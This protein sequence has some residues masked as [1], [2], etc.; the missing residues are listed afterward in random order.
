[1]KKLAL[2]FIAMGL[3]GYVCAQEQENEEEGMMSKRGISI[4][5]ESG[6]IGLGI[7]GIPI[8]SYFGNIFNGTA[9]NTAAF[10]FV[11]GNNAIYGKYFLDE[12]TAVRAKVRINTG[13]VTD[14]E[15]V[16]K[17][18][19]PYYDENT[20]KD[21]QHISTT[22]V[23]LSTG[24]EMRRGKG[25]IQGFYGGEVIATYTNRITTYEY[26]NAFSADITNPNT[27][28]FGSNVTYTASGTGV[29]SRVL[30]QK[31]GRQL[32]FGLG[33]FI[34]VEYFFAPKIAVGGEF[35]WGF[36]FTNTADGELTNEVYDVNNMVIT[37]KTVET[38]GGNSW[39]VDTDN[40]FGAIYLMFHF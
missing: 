31:N 17:D 21:Y 8:I 30:E 3:I 13:T 29:E 23:Y 25:R 18:T 34:G 1:M 2:I 40:A 33:G 32:G 14:M 22:N 15:Y 28:D 36:A 16:A 38:G 26:G 4:L 10:N 12:K 37:K 9:N 35:G 5:P 7:N 11:D 39:I 27:T 19:L 24:Y 20:V 6:D